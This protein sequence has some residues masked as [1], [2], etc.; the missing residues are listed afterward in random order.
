MVEEFSFKREWL[1]VVQDLPEGVRKDV[2]DSVILY[3]FGQDVPE[4]KPTARMY[5]TI[6]RTL[7]DATRRKSKHFRDLV[8]RRWNP[9]SDVNTS[10]NTSVNTDVYTEEISEKEEIPTEKVT[11]KELPVEEKEQEKDIDK[12]I[13]KK[14]DTLFPIEEA[15]TQEEKVAP[16]RRRFV[17]PTEEEVA[18]YCLE[19][20]NNIS[21]TQFINF[22]ESKGWMVG[23]NPMKD[24]KAAV[25]T[26]EQGR[27]RGGNTSYTSTTSKSTFVPLPTEQDY[28]NDGGF[29]V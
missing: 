25:R 8:N 13:S 18:A 6:I 3:A 27:S 17:K 10:V 5:F 15:G 12:S 9:D 24:W 28:I 29:Q 22:Y 16:K 23:S 20:K 26:W 19:R 7:I 2:V 4:L 1:E 14:N 11:Q 21:A